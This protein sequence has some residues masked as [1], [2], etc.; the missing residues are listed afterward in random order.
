MNIKRL[1]KKWFSNQEKVLD[2]KTGLQKFIATSFVSAA[3][4]ALILFIMGLCNTENNLQEKVTAYVTAALFW[5]SIG[6]QIYVTIKASVYR[7]HLEEKKIERQI[8]GIGAFCFFKNLEAIV[9]D[10]LLF[11]SAAS[12]V[13]MVWLGYDQQWVVLLCISLCFLSF[14]LHCIYNG[15]NYRYKKYQES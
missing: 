12:I 10:I 9:E 4:G 11:I 2:D 3:M 14:S 5:V 6:V 7:K 1:S 8:S 13:I 15:K